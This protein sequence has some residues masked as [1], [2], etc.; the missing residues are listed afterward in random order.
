MNDNIGM[1]DIA[2]GDCDLMND[3]IGMED[4]AIGDCNIAGRKR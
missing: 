4:I 3:N 1:E 2:I